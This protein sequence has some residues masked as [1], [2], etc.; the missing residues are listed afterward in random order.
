MKKQIDKI[1]WLVGILFAP[2]ILIFRFIFKTKEQ[3]G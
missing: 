2:I 1:I 3:G